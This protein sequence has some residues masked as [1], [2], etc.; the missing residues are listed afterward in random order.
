M[1]IKNLIHATT[2][3]VSGHLMRWMIIIKEYGPETHYIP[4]PEKIVANDM[5]RIHIINDGKKSNNHTYA[6]SLL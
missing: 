1:I 6:K 4:G 2:L 5:S 3:M